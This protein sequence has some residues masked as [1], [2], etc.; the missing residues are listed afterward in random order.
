MD[1]EVSATE[2]NE[3]DTVTFTLDYNNASGVGAALSA[4]MSERVPDGDW[5]G[6]GGTASGSLLYLPGTTDNIGLNFDAGDTT[7]TRTLTARDDSVY[8]G[9]Q[10]RDVRVVVS[11]GT[12]ATTQIT[13]KDD[14]MPSTVAT[15]SNLVVNDGASDLTLSP[16]F[17]TATLSYTASVANSIA[18]VTVTPT[19]THDGATVAYFDASDTELTDADEDPVTG[20]QASLDVGANTI[21]V[22]VTAQ[23]D[24]TTETYTVAVTR[25]AR[26]PDAPENLAA[27]AHSKH[28]KL[29]WEAPTD[30]GGSAVTKYQICVKASGA[31]AD[32]DWK[33]IPDSGSGEDNE[34]SY[35]VTQDSG[36]TALAN[37]TAYTFHVRAVNEI[38][39]GDAADVAETP[40]AVE[41]TLPTGHTQLLKAVLTVKATVAD[42]LGCHN[43]DTGVECSTA[44]V[45]SKDDFTYSGNREVS[46]LYLDWPDPR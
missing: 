43:P 33:D 26:A 11:G 14:E 28:V 44:S 15:L 35:T 13:V 34:D 17:A 21:K 39:S 19:T 8:T 6:I 4:A 30:N 45:L 41:P 27:A 42:N 16:V 32:G 10:V 40:V 18:Q 12:V 1:T 5:G 29:T 3:G 9:D 31:C 25:A 38:G 36:D 24:N 46:S 2:V 37:G 20:F 22:K 7:S 23:D